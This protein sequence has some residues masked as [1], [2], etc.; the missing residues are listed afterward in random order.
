MN[1]K[2]AAR[3]MLMRICDGK[4]VTITNFSDSVLQL[5]EL[6][7][8]YIESPNYLKPTEKGFFIEKRMR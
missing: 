2:P 7:L 8:A 4:P 3:I 6:E 5:F 1:L